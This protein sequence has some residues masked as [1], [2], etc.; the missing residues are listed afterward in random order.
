MSLSLEKAF[1][2]KYKIINT[3]K[4]LIYK[5][6]PFL[7]EKLD[8]ED[9]TVFL[10]P[11]LFAYFNSKKGNPFPNE[12]LEGILQGCFLEKEKIKVK[13]SFNKNDI[14]FIPEVG[15]FKKGKRT[16]YEPILKQGDFEIL[17]EVHPTQEKYFVEFYKGH[18]VN[19]NPEHN[20]VWKAHY[21]ELFE[22]ID[23]I[24]KQLP[25]FYEQLVFANKKIYLHDNSKILNF[26][27]AET[28]GMLYFYV[29]GNSNLIYFIEE[30]IHQGSH[31][32]LYYVVH[33]RKDFF[34]IDVDNLVMRDFTNQ[35]WDYRTIYGAFHGLFTVTQRVECFDKLLTKNVF[36]GREKHELLGRLTDQFA[37]Y[38]TGLELLDFNKVYTQKGIKFYNELDKK[39]ESILK[40]YSKLKSEFD[41]S[42][43]DLDF[44]YD[45]FCKLN[46]FEGFLKKDQ[47]NYYQF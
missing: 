14:A 7:F 15:Y 30:L 6:N 42:N 44:R 12:T 1:L 10:E 26:T 43:R 36:S 41:L 3:I 29:I 34:K 17:K 31:N 39:C 32:Y 38:K 25:E 45:D 4:L 35:Q 28:L 18:I 11:L 27:S 33:S 16:P 21:E 20:T 37:R 19:P 5:E 22:S 40:K 47:N 13:Y 46:S 24:K 9:V 2:N 8:F 23:I